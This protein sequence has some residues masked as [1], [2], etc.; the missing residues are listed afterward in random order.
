MGGTLRERGSVQGNWLI[1]SWQLGWEKLMVWLTALVLWGW[2]AV[3]ALGSLVLHPNR[4]PSRTERGRANSLKGKW[5]VGKEKQPETGKRAPASTVS[6][7]CAPR[8]TVAEAPG[9]REASPHTYT[10][11]LAAVPSWQHP[12][13]QAP[14]QHPGRRRRCPLRCSGHLGWVEGCWGAAAGTAH[15]Q[16][17]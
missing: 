16:L 4:I 11:N 14:L 1:S 2:R 3:V 7:R 17:K 12:H 10:R 5:P 13:S 9:L 6:H 15:H 8:G